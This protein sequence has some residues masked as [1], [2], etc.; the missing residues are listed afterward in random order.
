MPVEGPLPQ[1]GDQQDI[2]ADADRCFRA[3]I[4]RDWRAHG[5]DGTD[6]YGIDYQI[7]TTPGQRATDI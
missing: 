1:T 5:V 6:D 2:G 7:Q 3:R 4:P